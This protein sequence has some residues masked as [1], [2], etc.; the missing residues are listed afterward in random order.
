MMPSVCARKL[1][2]DADDDERRDD[3]GKTEQAE[4]DGGGAE[5]EQRHV[6]KLVPSGDGARTPEVVAIERGGVRNSRIA[7]QQRKDGGER[8][9][10][11][12]HRHH[13]AARG[14]RCAP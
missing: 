13:A 8:R 14:P 7:K 3:V 11:H 6:R 1:R 10:Q 5:H 12:Q 9:P 4:D 2:H